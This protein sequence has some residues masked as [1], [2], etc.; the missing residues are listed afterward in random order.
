MN[1]ILVHPEHGLDNWN[2]VEKVNT[3]ANHY[4]KMLDTTKT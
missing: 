1:V 4:V 3:A 2:L